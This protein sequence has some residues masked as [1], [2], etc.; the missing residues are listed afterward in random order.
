MHAA[1][2]LT[3]GLGI[4]HAFF[5][6][7][8]S[9]H[10]FVDSVR[11]SN[12]AKNPIG[13]DGPWNA[14][15]VSIGF[16]SLALFPG[17]MWQTM[18]LTSAY[19]S[20]NASTVH[21]TAGTYSKDK[22]I[23]DELNGVKFKPDAQD[24]MAG[25]QI[26]G[27]NLDTYFD[28]C[29]V[30]GAVPNCSL[31]LV[32]DQ[33]MSYPGGQW[34]PL[35]AGCLS[36][37]APDMHQSYSQQDGS[38]INATIFPWYL[39]NHG[40]MASSSFGMHIGSALSSSRL[41]G[42]LSFGGFDKNRA[43]GDVL[44]LDG[45][46]SQLVTLTDISIDV[47]KGRS[48]FGFT[49]KAGLLASGNSS[50]PNAGLPV[51][52]DGCSPYLTL[53]KSTCDSISAH[54]PLTYNDSLGLFLWKTDDAAF[55][56]LMSSASAL[57]F[58]FMGTDNTKSVTIKVPFQ[59]LN[60]TLEPPLVD[61]STSYFPCSTGG[62]GSYVLGRAFL[63]DAFVAGN[64]HRR[65]WWLAQAPGP[66]I[67]NNPDVVVIDPSDVS[68]RG[69]SNDWISSWDR[70]W[71]SLASSGNSSEPPR[72]SS[73]PAPA[74]VLSVGATAGIGAGVGIAALVLVGILIV[75]CWRR[76]QSQKIAVEGCSSSLTNVE[77]WAQKNTEQV[78]AAVEVPGSAVGRQQLK[79]HE[80]P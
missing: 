78:G 9:S 53:P 1:S 43:T 69:N 21:C 72:S 47:I 63:Q 14:V 8:T 73:H 27:K 74:S 75:W 40:S 13:P 67:P 76:R 77:T 59:H 7:T 16:D 28:D 6:E 29:N 24:L 49:K 46:P 2:R 55:A 70:V 52:V 11:Q 57:A 22:A 35:F 58:S 54:L 41:S 65:K 42:S 68:I 18:V 79:A 62:T 80:L 15:Q 3:L 48:P 71:A 66:N 5:F 51:T 37:G 60:L 38:L 56:R 12:W 32:D 34:Y 30:V 23:S 45:G 25:V 61:S 64:W 20:K 17:H 10:L 26:K 50:M 4:Q 44:T 33:M 19:Y 36:L 31:A 39:Y